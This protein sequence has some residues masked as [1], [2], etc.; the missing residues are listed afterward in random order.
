MAALRECP[1]CGKPA[2]CFLVCPP[3]GDFDNSCGCVNDR[4]PVQPRSVAPATKPMSTAIRLWN[5]RKGE[6]A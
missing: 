1:F 2:E 3:D 4:C 6:K 5:T